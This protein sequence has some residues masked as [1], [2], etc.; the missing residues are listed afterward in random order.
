M[1]IIKQNIAFSVLIK[2][3][4]LALVVAGMANLWLAV[5]ADMGASLL[6]IVNGMRL[7]RRLPDA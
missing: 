1:A 2:F 3:T 6:V 7:M 5:F 4:F